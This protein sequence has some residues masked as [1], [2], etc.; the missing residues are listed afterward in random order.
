MYIINITFKERIIMSLLTGIKNLFKKK[1]SVRV[2]QDKV[3]PRIT[4]VEVSDSEPNNEFKYIMEVQQEEDTMKDMQNMINE[5][6]SIM[7]DELISIGK[8]SPDQESFDIFLAKYK[9]T[10]YPL[11]EEFVNHPDYSVMDSNLNKAFVIY[12]FAQENFNMRSN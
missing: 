7:H 8:A 1:E 5:S 4:R 2:Y 12:K 11:L 3:D 10:S 6:V 9:D